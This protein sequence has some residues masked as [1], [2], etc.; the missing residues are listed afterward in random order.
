MPF[1][2]WLRQLASQRLITEHRK[3]V[4]SK[5]RSVLREQEFQSRRDDRSATKLSQILIQRGANPSEHVTAA[6]QHRRV[7]NALA[8]LDDLDRE[9]LVLRLVEE[10]ST[11]EA[12]AVLG[13]AEGT[14]GSRQYRALK[15][16][17]QHL[18]ARE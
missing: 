1:Y 7:L 12:A 11:K 13:I 15:R 3:H 10:L 8:Q 6:E 5:T 4:R 2:A 18:D 16:L 9:I 14:V 17:K